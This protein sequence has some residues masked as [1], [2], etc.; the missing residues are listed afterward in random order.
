MELFSA[1]AG[2]SRPGEAGFNRIGLGSSLGAVQDRLKPPVSA[3]N[4]ERK[5]IKLSGNTS[6]TTDSS[7]STI[8]G[9]SQDSY[10]LKQ[11]AVSESNT[12]SA[13]CG[14]SNVL[15]SNFS[16]KI[17]LSQPGHLSATE[18]PWQQQNVI[19]TSSNISPAKRTSVDAGEAEKKKFKAT[20]ITWP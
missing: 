4:M 18:K 12:V 5:V 13:S 17:Q 2:Q 1:N 10:N 6:R 11:S 16:Q 14:D 8:K 20:A 15:T 3:I 7:S 9:Q 19:D